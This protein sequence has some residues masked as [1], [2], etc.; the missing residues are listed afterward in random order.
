RE[1][2]LERT[3]LGLL[4]QRHLERQT[5]VRRQMEQSGRIRRAPSAR[6]ALDETLASTHS[7]EEIE[8]VAHLV[9]SP[10]ASVG[11]GENRPKGSSR[12]M[13]L[14]CRRRIVSLPAQRPA[15]A[16]GFDARLEVLTH[17]KSIDT[18]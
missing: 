8:R 6:Q 15:F 3:A 16:V 12:W 4:V 18:A 7:V 10:S 9:F 5:H 11:V 14:Q 17:A 13:A 2:A 1:L